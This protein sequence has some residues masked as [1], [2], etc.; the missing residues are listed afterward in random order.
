MLRDLTDKV[1]LSQVSIS[2]SLREQQNKATKKGA[3]GQEVV[4]EVAL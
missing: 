1:S 2:D 4:P 3:R